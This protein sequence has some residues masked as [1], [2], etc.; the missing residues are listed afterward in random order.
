MLMGGDCVHAAEI[1]SAG[2]LCSAVLVEMKSLNNL[3]WRPWQNRRKYTS[4]NHG[5]HRF[6]MII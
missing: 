1:I 6:L 5:V 2:N 3:K 4:E